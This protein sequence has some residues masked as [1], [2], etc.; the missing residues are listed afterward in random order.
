MPA[1]VTVTVGGSGADYST[2]SAAEAGEQADFVTLDQIVRV[3]CR[4]VN[5]TTSMTFSGSTTDATRYWDI[6][7]DNATGIW[8]DSHYR[9]VATGDGPRISFNDGYVRLRNLQFHITINDTFTRGLFQGT[10]SLPAASERWVD[11][12]IL[13]CTNTSTGTTIG[14]R[15]GTMGGGTAHRFL[16]R[17]TVV[18]GDWHIG[19]QDDGTSTV[20]YHNVTV[21]G[22]STAGFQS[23]FSNHSR[24][25]NCRATSC[26]SPFGPRTWNSG[27]NYNLTDGTGAP[28]ANSVNSAVVDY[29]NAATGDFRLDVD[30]DGINAGTDLSADA[31]LAVTVDIGGTARPQGAAFEIG[32]WEVVVSGTPE[33]GSNAPVTISTTGGGTKI[34]EGG[35]VSTVG[36]ST[37]GGGQKVAAGG[38]NAG[39]AVATTGAGTAT[40]AGGSEATV[41]VSTTG[42]AAKV[43][44]GGAA[45]TVTVTTTGGGTTIRQGGSSAPVSIST[46]G[47]GLKIGQ[48]GS[49]AIVEITAQGIA[50]AVIP[51][52][53]SL[54][55]TLT[56]TVGVSAVL[57]RLVGVSAT[58][59]P[60][61]SLTATLTPGGDA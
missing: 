61:L 29:V 17:N 22:A 7:G 31:D 14:A 24:A 47:A 30:D 34:A 2:L 48:G 36:V 38:S 46:T 49:I 19:F 10:G 33:G 28:G 51:L 1:I 25:R 60:D 13:R 39:V 20:F 32:A 15:I 58:A 56:A 50:A 8:S 4:E 23:G 18:Y 27:S 53:A 45:S 6:V 12:C 41:A 52:P 21:N 55:A 54:S 57:S 11:R 42:G 16:V 43:A 26:A 3:E 44:Q 59:T 35:S 40:K 5:D 37:T 9:R